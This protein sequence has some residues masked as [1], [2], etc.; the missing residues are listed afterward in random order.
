MTLPGLEASAALDTRAR[1]AAPRDGGQGARPALLQRLLGERGGE[2]PGGRGDPPREAHRAIEAHGPSAPTAHATS[3]TGG[4][5]TLDELL[6][7]A[8]EDLTAH[9]TV[10][11]LACG[12]AMTPRYGAGPEPV[13]G[14]CGGCGTTLA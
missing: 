13:G 12:A 9:R 3:R 6:V 4:G 7:G 1:R 14:R 10:S 2:E 11:C 5:V 8:W